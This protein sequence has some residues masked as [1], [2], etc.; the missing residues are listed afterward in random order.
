MVW[1]NFPW[2]LT[3]K[4]KK[5][6]SKEDSA[7]AVAVSCNFVHRYDK[8]CAQLR[9]NYF[10]TQ[11]L[12]TFCFDEQSQAAPH[13]LVAVAVDTLAVRIT[14][15]HT[16]RITC[17]HTLTRSHELS[18]QV[19]AH[20]REQH[21]T[22]AVAAARSSQDLTLAGLPV[23]TRLMTALSLST[24]SACLRHFPSSPHL[25]EAQVVCRRPTH[26][27]CLPIECRILC[28]RLS[29]L[30]MAFRRTE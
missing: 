19:P 7:V 20:A 13:S 3:S 27:V 4:L 2:V 22:A 18:P 17:A 1:S 24:W 25:A 26:H 8:F 5:T 30:W 10:I 16:T 11:N 21:P 12:L 29:V 9:Q 14:S 28:D 15:F 23:P 6:R